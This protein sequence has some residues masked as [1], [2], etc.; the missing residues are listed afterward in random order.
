MIILEKRIPK[1]PHHAC[2]VPQNSSAAGAGSMNFQI[3]GGLGAV[4]SVAAKGLLGRVGRGLGF[5]MG[6]RPSR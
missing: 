6:I 3:A 5:G 4:D 2:K 1:L